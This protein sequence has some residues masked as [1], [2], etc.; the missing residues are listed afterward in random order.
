MQRA[1]QRHGE[2]GQRDRKPD[3]E[4]R[5]GDEGRDR[6]ADEGG[7]R[8]AADDG[9][10]LGERTGGNGEE[11]DRGGADGRDDQREMRVV[12]HDE[13]ADEAGEANADQGSEAADQA[14]LERGA[15]ENGSEQPEFGQNA[16]FLGIMLRRGH[17]DPDQKKADDYSGGLCAYRAQH[18]RV[19]R[20]DS[21]LPRR[22]GKRPRTSGKID[23][24]KRRPGRLATPRKVTLSLFSPSMRNLL[25]YVFQDARWGKPHERSPI[26]GP[27]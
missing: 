26:R 1:G 10:G 21:V 8:V 18:A 15:G 9:P 6:H 3:G 23:R 27:R 19:H 2:N 16:R 13:A 14:F 20:E 7:N 25:E 12:A 4:R 24:K 17:D 22:C 11:Q 5:I